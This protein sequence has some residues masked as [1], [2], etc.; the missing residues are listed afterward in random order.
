MLLSIVN[1]YIYILYIFDNLNHLYI[2]YYRYYIMS[3]KYYI[4][5][6]VDRHSP[7][8]K[9]TSRGSAVAGDPPILTG[10]PVLVLRSAF[11]GEPPVSG[12]VA[13]W[14]ALFF[15]SPIPGVSSVGPYIELCRGFP[16]A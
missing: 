12:R 16:L 14:V 2:L 5:P 4:V 8:R 9:A 10:G 13:S 7:A 6:P 1:I 15:C 11:S 3:Y